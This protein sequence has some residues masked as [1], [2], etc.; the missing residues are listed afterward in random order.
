MISEA[1]LYD[2]KARVY[3]PGLG[4]FLQSDPIGYGS[5]LNAYAYARNDPAN[6]SDPTGALTVVCSP[7]QACPVE[8]IPMPIPEIPVYGHGH[9]PSEP[10]ITFDLTGDEVFQQ[11]GLPLASLA[12]LAKGI[13]KGITKPPKPP[14][15]SPNSAF[16]CNA[17]GELEFTPE[18]QKQA[19]A[20]FHALQDG[21]TKTNDFM[22][23]GGVGALFAR[24]PASP[25][26]G[27][28]SLFGTVTS[29]ITTGLGFRPLGF[30]IVP[31]M[32][33][34]AGC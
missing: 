24:G 16:R 17:N 15:S 26:L 30:T 25:I 4:R 11:G 18:Y 9:G 10:V 3:D 22:L 28:L 6:N 14:C 33:P 7:Q 27:A 31:P 2:Y 5:D 34:P 8:N 20:N 13:P 23:S 19:C 29:S 32:V 1:R 21:A 12:D